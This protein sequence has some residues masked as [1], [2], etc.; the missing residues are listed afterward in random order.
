LDELTK[1]T[2]YLQ[3]RKIIAC[4]FIVLFKILHLHTKIF[5]MK[6]LKAKTVAVYILFNLLYNGTYGQDSWVSYSKAV[7]A[8]SYVG[9]SFRLTALVR[10]ELDDDSAS[11]HLWA[12]VDKETGIGFFDNMGNRPIR[13]AGWKTYTIQGKIDSGITQLAFGVYCMYNGKFY[14]DNIKLD[15]ETGKNKWKN[16]YTANFEDGTSDSLQEGIQRWQSGFSH[17]YTTTV[18]PSNGNTG[19]VFL[20]E[21]KNVPNYG[22]NSKVGKFADVNGIKLYYEIYGSGAPLVVL[23]GN[24]G[25]IE[26]ASPFYGDLMKQYKVIAVDSRSQG[27]STTTAAPLN[28]DIMASDVNA[29][30]TQLHIDSAFIWGQSDGAILG[31]LLAKDYPD[32]VKRVLA[33]GPNIQPDSLALYPWVLDY[34]HKQ[35]QSK[36]VKERALSQMM[37][38][39]PN[40]PYSALA[41]IK[42]PVLVMCGDRD[43]IRPEHI[44]KIYQNIPNSQL[45]I[46]PGSTHFGA[47]DN[48]EM[49]LKIMNNFFNKPFTMPN[50]KDLFQR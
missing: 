30:L 28:Y 18:V 8:A 25:S 47:W 48:K 33:Y 10:T 39:Y 32:K 11:A 36:D 45:C 40:M 44:V 12:R 6:S 46:L 5:F 49:F 15:V 13:D 16:L 29:L 37:L 31:L 9:H 3:C 50:T 19:K 20:I 17:D 41:T 1:K 42:A 27:N 26:D 21:G 22:F 35:V 23:H 7:N 14:F 4:S 24:G 34:M 2:A 43:A 38:D